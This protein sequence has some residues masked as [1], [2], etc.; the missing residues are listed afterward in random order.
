MKITEIKNFKNECII[1]RDCEFDVLGLIGKTYP[2]HVKRVCFLEDSKYVNEFLNDNMSGVICTEKIALEILHKFSGGICISDKPRSTFFGF[3]NYLVSNSNYYESKNET[4]ID[5]GSNIHK[6][7]SIED[8]RVSIG[9]N[10]SI[11]ANVVIHA[12]VVIGDNVFIREGSVIGAP[13]FYYFI[14]DY[15]RKLVQSAGTVL[16]ENEVEIHSCV[17][18]CKGV[19]GG[20]TV[21]RESSKIDSHVF[22]GHDTKIGKQCTVA[23]NTTFGGGACIGDNVFVGVSASFA[24]NVQVGNNVKISMGSIVTKNVQDN[25]QVSGNFAID[26]KSF[27]KHIKKISK[28]IK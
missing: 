12:G 18:V 5:I 20:Q 17:V 26:H 28:I 15:E 24:P 19:L 14:D 23:A 16:I 6:S 11:A 3:H 1:K 27:I 2:D 21:I 4:R 13:A 8:H 25:M 7:A 10:V 22:I 9:K